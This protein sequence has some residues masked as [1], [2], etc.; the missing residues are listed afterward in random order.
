[1][2]ND[3]KGDALELLLGWIVHGLTVS[4]ALL[5]LSAQLVQPLRSVGRIAGV[6]VG[7]RLVLLRMILSVLS[8]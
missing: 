2:G 5:V 6:V 8:V 1:M 3:G 7:I 4:L